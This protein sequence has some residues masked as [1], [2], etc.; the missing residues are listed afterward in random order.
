MDCIFLKK[1]KNPCFFFDFS[2]IDRFH[3]YYTLSW[4]VLLQRLLHV[5][6]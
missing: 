5:Y 2:Q 6:V 1:Y 3:I 4:K